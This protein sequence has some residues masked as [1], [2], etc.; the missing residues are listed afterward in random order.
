MDKKK[1]KYEA[2]KSQNISGVV[3]GACS[4]T[5]ATYAI[6]TNCP[7]GNNAGNVCNL[8]SIADNNCNNGVYAA[9]NCNDGGN[10]NT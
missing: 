4:P 6:G 9:Q 7:S 10:T 5:G 3:Q 8:G 1:Q 2:P